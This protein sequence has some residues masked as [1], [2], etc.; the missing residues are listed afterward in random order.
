M[1]DIRN[2]LLGALVATLV[3]IGAAKAAGP[4]L[5]GDSQI[6]SRDRFSD[7]IVGSGPAIVF[8]PGL[9]SSR[10]TWKAQAERLR[11][12]YRVH[13]IQLAGF[14][15][16]P[17]RANGVGEVLVPTAEAIDA[18]L[19]EQHLA[20]AVVIGHSLGGT[21][22][23]YLCE[24]HGDHLKKVLIVDALPF[25]ATAMMGP[26]ATLDSVKP[27]ADMIRASTQPAP[28]MDQMIARMVS[29]PGNRAMV[30]AWGAASDRGT[31]N[32]ALA[33]DLMLDL[34][35][36]LASIG[37]P[38]T[39]L[40]PDNVPS[41]AAKGAMDGFY[42]A[43]FAAVPQKTLIRIDDSLHFIMLDQPAQFDAALD[44]FLKG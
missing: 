15:G 24:H 29:A 22:A 36:G 4:Q 9:A 28:N 1:F 43:A 25:Y 12:H 13:L 6:V 2:L 26:S 33:D 23:L 34:R 16:E 37:V 11:T 10:E 42:Q 32:R 19:A 40:Y 21:I 18:Y 38:I 41:G 27:M 14:A 8:I 17:A 44:A 31:V 39:L 20:P 5:F 7:E 35:P 30:A 3:S